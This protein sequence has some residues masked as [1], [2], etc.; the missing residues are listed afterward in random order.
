VVDL[1]AGYATDV[2]AI[3]PSDRYDRFTGAPILAGLP[4]RVE[5]A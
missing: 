1:P 5:R 2:G 3:I 4:C